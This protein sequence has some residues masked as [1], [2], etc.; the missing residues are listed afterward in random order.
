MFSKASEMHS[1]K[2]QK[3]HSLTSEKNNYVTKKRIQERLNNQK[4]N[5]KHLLGLPEF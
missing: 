3:F 2:Y 5:E 4:N 1:E